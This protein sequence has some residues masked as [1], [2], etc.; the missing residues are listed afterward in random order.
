LPL[1]L[2]NYYECMMKCIK[3]FL[4]HADIRQNGC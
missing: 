3:R 1:C 4:L 2:S